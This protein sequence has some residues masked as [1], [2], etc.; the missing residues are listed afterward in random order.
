MLIAGL[1][2]VLTM[3]FGGFGALQLVFQLRVNNLVPM[4]VLSLRSVLWA[5]AVV[6]IYLR[7]LR[8]G[9]ARDRPVGDDCDRHVRPGLGGVRLADRWPAPSRARVAPL[10]RAAI[11]LGISGMLIIAYARIDQILVFRIS[12][13]RAGG[14]LRQRL[15]RP[16]PGALRADLDPHDARSGDGGGL[17]GGSP[18]GCC[19]TARLTA[20]LMAIAPSAALAFAIVASTP[21]VQLIFGKEFL[22]AAPALP[23]LGAALSYSSASAT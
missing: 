7:R 10:M 20:E 12:R 9:R 16:R 22:P 15:Q 11:P 4:L 13:Q 3:P 8:H 23:V 19:A 14:P 18:R 6:V 5:L 21:L 1:I 17:A 2:L